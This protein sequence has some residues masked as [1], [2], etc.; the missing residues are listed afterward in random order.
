[1]ENLENL[2]A[3]I[4]KVDDEIVK[5]FVE[6][7]KIVEEV[8]KVK[9]DSSIGVNNS[10]REKEILLRLTSGLSDEL[11][12]YLIEIYNTIFNTSKVYQSRFIDKNSKTVDKIKEVLSG[13]AKEFPIVANV[14]CQGVEGAFSGIAA[15]KFFKVP[16]VT[17]FKNFEGVFSAVDKGFCEYGVLPIENSTAGSVFEVYD[18]MK[19]HNFSI[20]RSI[21]LKVDHCL[22]VNV[23]VQLQDIKKVVSHNQ[24]L[25]QCSAYL[26]NLKVETEVANNTAI[27]AKE[28]KESGRSD[29]AVICSRSCAEEYSLKILDSGIQDSSKNYTR[30]ILISK[31]LKLFANSNKISVMVSLEHTPGSL[32]KIL[33]KFNALNLNL[34]KLESR[35]IVNSD[36][37]FMFYFDFDGSVEDKGV[38]ELLSE[39]ENSSENF[40]L[41]GAY[42]EIV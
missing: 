34:T 28:L 25:L 42:K 4:D 9:K 2:R 24:A 14:A 5:L 15:E 19:K 33:G 30:F 8:A 17:Y 7:M 39:L 21:K 10:K 29:V 38:L 37:E 35:P 18:L 41:L 20:V 1:M 27:A 12:V 26:K 31:E 36:F 3:K 13:E 22:V 40:V 32:Y 11:K 6:R 16:N 23:G